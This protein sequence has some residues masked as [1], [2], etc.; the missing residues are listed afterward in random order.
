MADLGLRTLDGAVKTIRAE[1]LQAFGAELRG[2]L[3]DANS[4][5]YDQARTIWN[6]MIDRRPGLIAR[7]CGAADVMSAVRFARKHGV[8]VAVRGG[9]HNIAGNGICDGGLVIDLSLMK[10]VRVDHC[11][12]SA[13]TAKLKSRSSSGMLS[14]WRH[15]GGAVALHWS[16]RRGDSYHRHLTMAERC[17][18]TRVANDH[19]ET[20]GLLPRRISDYRNE[21]THGAFTLPNMLLMGRNGFKVL[22]GFCGSRFGPPREARVPM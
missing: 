21:Q 2:A 1:E 11:A 20:L 9:G 12:E 19:V 8:V 22:S 3:I 18:F 6:A 14:A 16:F 13:G 15:G 4:P 17:S 7:C 5:N 10:S